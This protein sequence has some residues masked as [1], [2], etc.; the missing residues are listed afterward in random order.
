[1]PFSWKDQKIK[2]RL[3]QIQ[4]CTQ[5][6][7]CNQEWGSQHPELKKE[8]L[9]KSITKKVELEKYIDKM[10]DRKFNYGATPKST[11]VPKRFNR[12]V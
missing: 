10:L 9:N 1:M 4:R 11:L 7:T 12:V 2:A 6:A 3:K 8:I 5:L